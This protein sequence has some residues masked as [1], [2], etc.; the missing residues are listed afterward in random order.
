MNE[1]ACDVLNRI[2][3][4]LLTLINQSN[5]TSPSPTTT[6]VAPISHTTDIVTLDG[7]G[8]VL[9]YDDFE[10][11]LKWQTTAG[12]GIGTAV[13]LDDTKAYYG[14]KS[15]KLTGIAGGDYVGTEKRFLVPNNQVVGIELAIFTDIT[16]QIDR[17]NILIQMYD[18]F[19]ASNIDF[20]WDLTTKQLTLY[21]ANTNTDIIIESKY[22]HDRNNPIWHRFKF[23]LD[24]SGSTTPTLVKHIASLNKTW[25]I[26]GIVPERASSTG[27][28]YLRVAVLGY[29]AGIMNIDNFILTKED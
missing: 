12:G 24:F 25:N 4:N 14:T 6:V 21:D 9:W 10:G 13:A 7:K 18:G 11:V 23:V 19:Y 27:S 8:K 5:S 15:I 28:P 16:N 1:N 29:G 20:K 2:N 17:I 26:S 3:S 22:D